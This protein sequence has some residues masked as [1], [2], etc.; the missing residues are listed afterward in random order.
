MSENPYMIK[1]YLYK[2]FNS[3][4][5]KNQYILAIYKNIYLLDTLIMKILI[6]I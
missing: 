2:Y 1:I 6:I 3:T 4:T 5:L